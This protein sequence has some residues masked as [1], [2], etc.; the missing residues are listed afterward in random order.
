MTAK[1]ILSLIESVDPSDTEKM[2]EIELRAY[3][4]IKNEGFLGVGKNEAGQDKYIFAREYINGPGKYQLFKSEI[5]KYTRSRDA[6]KCIRPE[7]WAAFSMDFYGAFSDIRFW[8]CELGKPGKAVASTGLPTEEL[9]EL[10]A[11]IQSLEH[12][13]TER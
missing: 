3:S 12:E 7:G 13:R 2:D 5:P 8:K 4:Y 11:I 9:A 10:H 6:L 1:D